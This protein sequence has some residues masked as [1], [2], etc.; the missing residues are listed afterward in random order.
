MPYALA[1]F[2]LG[3][4]LA[5]ATGHPRVLGYLALYVATNVVYT[6]GGKQVPILDVFLLASG[7]VLRVLMGCAL[8]DA[9]PSNWLLT[10]S[11]WVALF[12][13]FAKR[14]AD[15]ARGMGAEVQPARIGYRVGFLDQA[16]SIAAGVTLMSYVLYS[17]EAAVFV[18]G[19]RTGRDALRRLRPAPLPASR[20]HGR[21]ARLA[22]RDGVALAH[23][24][25]LL[26]GLADRDALEPRCLLTPFRVRSAEQS[27]RRHD[28]RVPRSE[29]QPS[30]EVHQAAPARA[31][32]SP[33]HHRPA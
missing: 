24:P 6:L 10:C 11:L 23:A 32:T 19:P 5:W 30:G 8:V 1:L 18:R 15:F 16:M 21:G 26:A 2:A 31:T 17:Q 13:G 9:A 14:R 20:T 22:G 27:A 25:D 28:L 29:A 4:A 3:F 7:F 12:L 33:L